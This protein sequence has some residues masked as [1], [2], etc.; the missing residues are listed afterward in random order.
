MD[1]EGM[2]TGITAITP[3]IKSIIFIFALIGFGTKAG[4]IP[5]HTWIPHAYSVAP[6]HIAALMS[7]LMVKMGIY[8]FLRIAMDVLGQGPEW[9]GIAVISVG[10]VSALLGILYGLVE[11]DLKVFLA[12][13]SVENIGII[14]LGIGAS[15]MFKSSG[16]A[17]L[18]S[19]SLTAAL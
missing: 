18:S 19:I 1:F 11:N 4:I 15:M 13:S 6:P 2:K 9:W 12:Y 5:L 7:G 16:L 8:G 14:L 3:A 10:A 17:A